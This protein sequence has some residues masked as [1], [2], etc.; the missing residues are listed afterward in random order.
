MP[1]LCDFLITDTCCTLVVISLLRDLIGFHQSVMK[2][3]RRHNTHRKRS[4]MDDQ[5]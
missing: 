1:F 4:R 5:M 3:M 2:E